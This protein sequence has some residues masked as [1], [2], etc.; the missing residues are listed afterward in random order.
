MPARD[1]QGQGPV[2]TP[3]DG[4]RLGLLN[5]MPDKALRV[6]ERQFAQLCGLTGADDLVCFGVPGEPT[7]MLMHPLRNKKLNT[8]GNRS[9]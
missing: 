7:L 3:K 6:T 2:R 5:M 8:F 1:P 9:M 4:M